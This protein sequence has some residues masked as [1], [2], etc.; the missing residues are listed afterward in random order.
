MHETEVQDAVMEICHTI[1]KAFDPFRITESAEGEYEGV[2]KLNWEKRVERLERA[3][4]PARKMR[5]EFA[6][7]KDEVNNKLPGMRFSERVPHFIWLKERTQFT[8]GC[9]FGMKMAGSSMEEIERAARVIVT[10]QRK[11]CWMNDDR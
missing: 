2:E 10:R 4:F 8:V 7:L 5:Q 9:L 3:T 11:E 6:E 1:E